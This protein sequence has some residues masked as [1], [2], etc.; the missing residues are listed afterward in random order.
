MKIYEP[1]EAAMKDGHHSVVTQT[2]EARY[3]EDA[4]VLALGSG[5]LPSIF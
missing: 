4:F 1:I 5:N 2:S 3:P